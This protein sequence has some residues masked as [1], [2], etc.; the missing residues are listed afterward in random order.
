MGGKTGTT[1]SYADGWFIGISPQLVAGAWVGADDPG[2][3]FRSSSLGQ[4]AS[5]ALP[6]YALFWQQ[7]N[8]DSTFSSFTNA[9]CNLDREVSNLMACEPYQEPMDMGLFDKIFGGRSSE[10]NDKPDRNGRGNNRR[11]KEDNNKKKKG[12]LDKIFGGGN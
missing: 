12:L 1:Q 3:R 10:D 7:V 5:T 2:I 6:V 11:N 8:K 9:K 4:G